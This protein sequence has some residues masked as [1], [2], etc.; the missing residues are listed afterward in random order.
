MARTTLVPLRGARTMKI[1]LNVE[2]ARLASMSCKGELLSSRGRRLRPYNIPGKCSS[3]TDGEYRQWSFNSA[4]RF[5]CHT[6]S[7]RHERQGEIFCRQE[8]EHRTVD[9]PE[10]LEV[11]ALG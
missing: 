3:R 5:G 2:S 4:Q 11:I 9:Y 8:G 6:G 10:V 7:I 1:G